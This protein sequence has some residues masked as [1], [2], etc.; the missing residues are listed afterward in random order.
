MRRPPFH[1]ARLVPR[2][3]TLAESFVF[4]ALLT[5]LRFT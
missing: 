5:V 2:L 1:P 4:L 3:E